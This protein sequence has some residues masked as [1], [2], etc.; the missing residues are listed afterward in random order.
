M[1]HEEEMC[2]TNV[3]RKYFPVIR[4]REEVLDEITGNDRLLAVFREWSRDQQELFLDY[5][6]GQRGVRILYDTFFKEILNPDR[7]PERVEEL[8]SLI[9]EQKVKILKVLPLES[10]RLGDE[11]S[12]VVM[13]VV[14]ELEDHSIA[15]LE[16]QKAGYYF[17]GRGRPVTHLTCS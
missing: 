6:S 17:P 10:P 16:V 7:T 12:L 14:V 9:L 8:L 15:N 4:T 1:P 3:L 13:D 2:M 5:C 11:Q